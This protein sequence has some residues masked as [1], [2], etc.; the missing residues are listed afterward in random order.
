MQHQRA[1]QQVRRGRC[2][3]LHEAV[4]GGTNQ[5]LALALHPLCRS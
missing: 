2:I 5:R 3:A 4:D 1:L